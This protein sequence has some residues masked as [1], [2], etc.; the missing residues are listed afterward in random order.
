MKKECSEE[1]H[2]ARRANLQLLEHRFLRILTDSKAGEEQTQAVAGAVVQ[3]PSL[4]SVFSGAVQTRHSLVGPML[5]GGTSEA[6][7]PRTYESIAT[8]ASDNSNN[9][10]SRMALYG[11]GPSASLSDRALGRDGATASD[12]LAGTAAAQNMAAAT[13]NHRD[14]CMSLLRDNSV[15]GMERMLLAQRASQLALLENAQMQ[16]IGASRSGGGN[17]LGH[18]PTGIG[19]GR[20]ALQGSFHDGRAFSGMSALRDLSAEQPMSNLEA[21]L[22]GATNQSMHVLSGNVSLDD[23]SIN[24]RLAALSQMDLL[25]AQSMIGAPGAAA[26]MRLWEDQHRRA[27]AQSHAQHVLSTPNGA[28]SRGQPEGESGRDP[29]RAHGDDWA[30]GDSSNKRGKYM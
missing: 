11:L 5:Q 30:T 13:L 3:Q 28:S 9:L 1:Q 15:S 27:I 4:R 2:L 17:L 29:K 18:A 7:S 26:G 20:N 6:P 22:L 8:L 25:R 24:S 23:L 21:S 14:Q 16:Q 12:Y 10:R 19:Q